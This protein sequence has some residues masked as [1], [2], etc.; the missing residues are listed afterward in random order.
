MLKKLSVAATADIIPLGIMDDIAS[1]SRKLGKRLK[2]IIGIINP[3]IPGVP[4]VN[5]EQIFFYADVDGFLRAK[6]INVPN[7]SELDADY[8]ETLPVAARL[9]HCYSHLEYFSPSLKKEE[10]DATAKAIIKHIAA[11]YSAPMSPDLVVRVYI[12]CC[13]MLER[14]YTA[15]PVPMPLDADAAIDENLIWFTK[16]KEIM[17]Q[18]CAEMGVSLVE[19]EVYYFMMTLPIEGL[20]L[21][22][23]R[24]EDKNEKIERQ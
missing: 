15:E 4:F 24:K 12:H 10:V 6:G 14:M 3:K 21:D 22:G 16:L 18:A 2:L 1:I 11:M 8:I 17:S 7:E 13:T 5:M 23:C 19:A 9:E 20:I